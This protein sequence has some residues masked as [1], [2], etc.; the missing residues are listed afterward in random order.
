[1]VSTVERFWISFILR[2]AFGFL[3]LFAALNMFN[4]G[5]E[6]FAEDLSKPM[7][8]TWMGDLDA[9]VVSLVDQ[10]D[11][12]AAMTSVQKGQRGMS[13]CFLYGLPYLM[14]GIAVCILTGILLR[15]ALRLCALL[16]VMLGL[17]KYLQ[18]DISTTAAD[19]SFALMICIGLYFLSLQR[20]RR[21]AD[22]PVGEEMAAV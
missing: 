8:A 17:G 1:M 19:F 5:V 16:M 22:E 9:K 14:T 12:E 6:K 11:Y 2:F 20:Q 7:A 10:T 18:N 21:S 15:F 13:Y 4:Y 3:F